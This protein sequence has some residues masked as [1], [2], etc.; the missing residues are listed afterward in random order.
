MSNQEKIDKPESF[1]QLN[2]SH[3]FKHNQ[4]FRSWLYI[5]TR[6]RYRLP[7]LYHIKKQAAQVTILRTAPLTHDERSSLTRASHQSH[8]AHD[9]A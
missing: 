5:K 7:T 4:V 1:L 9:V 8:D 2:C 3:N 6:I